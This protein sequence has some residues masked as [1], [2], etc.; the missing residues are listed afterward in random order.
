MRGTCF[1]AVGVNVATIIIVTIGLD[2]GQQMQQVLQM[3]SVYG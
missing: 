2:I 3:S 1:V